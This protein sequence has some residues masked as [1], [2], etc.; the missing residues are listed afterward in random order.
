MG[1]ARATDHSTTEAGAKGRIERK[2]EQA[3]KAGS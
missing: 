2:S 1:T 3:G